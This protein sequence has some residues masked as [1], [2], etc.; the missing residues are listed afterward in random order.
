MRTN[1]RILLE[2]VAD[3]LEHKGI[4]LKVRDDVEESLRKDIQKSEKQDMDYI[5]YRQKSPAEIILTI[6][7]NIYIMQFNT[8][9][10]FILNFVL[11]SYLYDKQLVQFG[12]A[13]GLSMIYIVVILPLSIVVYGRITRKTYLY[14]NKIER[15]LGIL[16][17]II[18][19][20]LIVMHT[21][22]VTLGIFIVTRYA[23]M[24]IAILGVI[25]TLYGLYRS[26][27]EYMGIGLLFI[28]KT[29]DVMI[30]YTQ[31]AQ[32]ISM[33]LWIVLLVMFIV[34]II[35]FSSRKTR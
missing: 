7:K 5:E 12:A 3:Y 32:Y 16:L 25:A 33:A 28:Q 31:V 18:A 24:T 4:A 20:I 11:L 1:D 21:F 22:D 9:I 13:T 19:F 2:N 8:I 10:F 34:Y 17:A 23:H 26:Y 27:F 29:I 15:Y 6:Q 14:H 35:E 30:P